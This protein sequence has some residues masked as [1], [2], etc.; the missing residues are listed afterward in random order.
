MSY[1]AYVST[2]DGDSLTV[3]SKANGEKIG[4]ISNGTEVIVT[5]EPVS[6]GGR[7][8]VQIGTNRWVASEFLKVIKTAKVIAKR[9]TKT[10]SG[11]LRVY[12]T[13]LIDSNG[14]VVNTVR[15]ISG[16]VNNQTPSQTAGSQTPIP[17][18]IYTFTSPGVVEYKGGEFGGVWSPV[19]PNF[20]TG[21]SELGVHY[22]PSAFQQ[23]GNTGTAGCFATP[24]VEE[25]DIMTKFIRGYK[26]THFVVYEG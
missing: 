21:R 1:T 17:F 9:T 13:R 4:S 14:K 10:I 23:N 8:W 24:T 11:G 7:N 15:G 16:R 25:R 18:G 2:K 20:N 26:P 6:A 3:R 5:G 19:T 12:E 22:D